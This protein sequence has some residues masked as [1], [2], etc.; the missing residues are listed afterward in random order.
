[1]GAP[2]AQ[3]QRDQVDGGFGGASERRSGHAGHP[4]LWSHNHGS[5]PT[6]IFPGM[7]GIDSRGKLLMA[8]LLILLPLLTSA[9]A[10]RPWRLSASPKI[11]VD[12][13]AGC[14]SSVIGY[15]DVVNTYS[16]P[17][18]VPPDP[19]SGIICRYHPEGGAPSSD[20]GQLARQTR[21]DSTKAGELAKAIRGLSLRPPSPRPVDCPVDIGAFVLI[22]LSYP[23]R[24]DVGLW[25]KT[26]G[27]QTLD[28]GRLG[29]WE[30]GHPSFYKTFL[31]LIGQLSPPL[32]VP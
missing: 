18:L 4:S 15:M 31:D 22:G 14:P 1:M 24:P 17:R 29:A 9:C 20:H 2:N 6:V 7:N 16:G 25:N 27:C 12:V 5:M 23:S 19:K 30:L 11:Q 21:L 10:A 3:E 32:P 13:A 8:G 26:S 28:N